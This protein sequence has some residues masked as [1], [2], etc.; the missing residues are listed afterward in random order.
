VIRFGRLLCDCATIEWKFIG[1]TTQW[2]PYVELKS[3]SS[4]V[5]RTA[6]KVELGSESPLRILEP[7]T[8]RSPTAGRTTYH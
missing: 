3:G 1:N 2:N 6:L 7:S 8:L 5:P 4:I